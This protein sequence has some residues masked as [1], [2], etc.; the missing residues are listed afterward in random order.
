MAAPGY[1]GEH[2]IVI[3]RDD[4]MDELIVQVEYE[5]IVHADAIP[6][7]TAA[8]S[9]RLRTVLGIGAKV[10]PVPQRTFDRTEFKA[11]RVIDDRDLHGSLVTGEERS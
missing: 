7:W 6:G 11:R 3:S 2:R 1:G 5:D 9:G 8:L 4:L 10:V